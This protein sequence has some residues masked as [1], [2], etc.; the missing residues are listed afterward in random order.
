MMEKLI[1]NNILITKMIVLFNNKNLNIDY[2]KKNLFFLTL[3]SN[4]KL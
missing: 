1:I 2:N 4:Y 3:I